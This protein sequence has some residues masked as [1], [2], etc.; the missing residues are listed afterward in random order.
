MRSKVEDGA[1][2]VAW[3][4]CIGF[5]SWRVHVIKRLVSRV[6]PSAAVTPESENEMS[7]ETLSR[8]FH[9]STR[10]RVDRDSRD[11]DRVYFHIFVERESRDT[12]V[13][14]CTRLRERVRGSS[15]TRAARGARE[16]TEKDTLLRS[17]CNVDRPQDTCCHGLRCRYGTLYST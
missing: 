16:Q 5:L 1:P 11:P 10:D 17:T 6:F 12:R 4:D 14:A 7:D 2:P 9:D 15:A 3:R 13:R 8:D